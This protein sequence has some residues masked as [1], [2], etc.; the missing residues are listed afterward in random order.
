MRFHDLIPPS[1]LDSPLPLNLW[2]NMWKVIEPEVAA[3]VAV[4][5]DSPLHLFA[6]ALGIVPQDAP[7]S[8]PGSR[9]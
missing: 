6:S 3:Q 2:P 1:M 9:A 4:M 7:S 8:D 5:S